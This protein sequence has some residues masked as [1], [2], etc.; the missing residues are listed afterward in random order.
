[1]KLKSNI[2]GKIPSAASKIL[3]D[4]FYSPHFVGYFIRG[5]TLLV[6]EDFLKEMSKFDVNDELRNRLVNSLINLSQ[7]HITDKDKQHEQKEN[8]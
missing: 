6:P 3:G 2:P 7:L 5:I 1:M 8:K 4:H